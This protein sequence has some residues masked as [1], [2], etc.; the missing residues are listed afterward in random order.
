MRTRPLTATLAAVLLA[1]GCGG[2]GSSTQAPPAQAADRLQAARDAATRA[3]DGTKPGGTLNLLGVLSGPQL[4]AYLG[5]FAPFEEAT[6]IKIKYESTGDVFAVLQTRIA[7][8]NPPDVVSNP[9]AGQV[10][11][12]AEQ[13]KLVALDPFLDMDEVRADYPE[14]LLNLSTMGGK[15]HGVFYNTAVQGLVWY[16]PKTYQG[17][18]PPA[19]WDELSTWAQQKSAA[20]TTPW[21]I[22][23][24]SGPSS[25][26]PGAVWIEEFMLQQAGPEVYTKWW[27]G[28]LPWTAPEIRQAFERFGAIAT[29]AEQ[30]SGGPTAVLTTDFNSSPQG[31]YADPPACHLHVQADFLGNALAQTVPGVVPG[32]DIDFFPF[33]PVDPARAGSV[34][35]SGETLALLK[36]SPQGRAFMRYVATPE[37]SALVA[38]TGQWI[39]ANRR[40]PL[41]AYTSVLSRRAAE[42]YADAKTVQYAAQNAMPLAMTQAFL[43]AVLAYVEKPSTLDAQLA[44]L[45]QAR[46]GAYKS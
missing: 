12:L 41:D 7:G 16:D 37:F 3:A 1:A 44:G 28:E 10:A 40:T 4:D 17:P 27:K 29:D 15:L 45:E 20:G 2:S 19:S 5:T 6:G 13:G 23:L 9:S 8:G 42:V 39:A 24:E 18:K 33:P 30:V 38:G 43:K 25:G 35:I 11:Q 31:L 14:G 34:E 21:C 32:T 22:G 36:D 26:W 46:A